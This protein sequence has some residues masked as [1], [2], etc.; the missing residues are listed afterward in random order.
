ME[1]DVSGDVAVVQQMTQL[2]QLYLFN[3]MVSGD[4]IAFSQLVLMTDLQ[5]ITERTL[6]ASVY[7]PDI[8]RSLRCTTQDSLV[9]GSRH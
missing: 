6:Y 7:C 3:T 1:T 2:N 8:L 9:L 4:I 5:V